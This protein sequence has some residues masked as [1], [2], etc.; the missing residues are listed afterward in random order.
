MDRPLAAALVVCLVAGDGRRSGAAPLAVQGPIERLGAKT[1]KVERV[2]VVLEHAYYSS[3]RRT[4]LG[5]LEAWF[6]RK[7]KRCLTHSR[8][9]YRNRPGA[10]GRTWSRGVLV[11]ERGA[12]TWSRR[13]GALRECYRH[14]VDRFLPAPGR[15]AAHHY[16][17]GC[18]LDGL[19]GYRNLT[20]VFT[21]RPAAA[22]LPEHKQ[23]RWFAAQVNPGEPEGQQLQWLT[24]EGYETFVGFDAATG[25]L[26][27]MITR[28]PNTWRSVVTVKK[29]EADPNLT[30]VFVL[31]DDVRQAE[32][33]D[34]KTR[35]PIPEHER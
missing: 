7:A 4:Q 28:H 20:R 11:N 10:A 1:A 35:E 34:A 3:G 18:L 27:A 26:K 15:L 2:H 24:R 6:D 12:T 14:P 33:L 8:W 21:L 31:P 25:W 5:K 9:E 17:P 16:A 29:V 13:D 30:G 19:Y 23:L 22:P 32:I